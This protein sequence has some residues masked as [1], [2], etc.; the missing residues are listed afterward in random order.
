MAA[1]SL[2]ELTLAVGCAAPEL[3]SRPPD[4]AGRVIA[5]GTAADGSRGLAVELLRPDSVSPQYG[6]PGPSLGGVVATLELEPGAE[7]L[8]RDTDG[9]IRRVALSANWVGHTV[10]VWV[11]QPLR[12]PSGASFEALAAAVVLD[13]VPAPPGPP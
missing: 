3:P 8:V 9:T 1:R 6:Q 10:S 5:A 7:S 11:A 13:R 4:F 2:L 12:V